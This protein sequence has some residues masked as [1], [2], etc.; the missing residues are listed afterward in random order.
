MRDIIGYPLDYLTGS[1]M[2]RKNIISHQ[3]ISIHEKAL[4]FRPDT[5][6]GH[7]LHL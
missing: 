3:L 7:E 6:H 1:F 4:N 5:L 2:E